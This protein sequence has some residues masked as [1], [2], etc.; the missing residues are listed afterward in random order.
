MARIKYSEELIKLISLFESV[1]KANV[2]DCFFND[3]GQ[4]FFVVEQGEISKAIGIKASNVRKIESLIKKKFRIVE[5]NENVLEFIKSLVYPIPIKEIEEVNGMVE[6]KGLDTKTK[7]LLIGRNAMNI[8]N[9]EKI[10]KRYF[11]VGG[12]KVV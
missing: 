8:K 11:D 2:K 4:L 12:L 3:Y 5:F 9:Y 7:G 6:I 10:V 1:T